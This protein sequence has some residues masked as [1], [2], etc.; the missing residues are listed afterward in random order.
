MNISIYKY[1]RC[2]DKDY[3]E[4]QLTNDNG[5]KVVLLNYG[6]TLEKILLPTCK[7]PKNVIMT[8]PGSQSYS[9]ERNFLGG[10]VG[11]VVGRIKNGKWNLGQ[12][13]IQFPLNDGENHIHGGNGFDTRVFA[14]STRYEK[15][16]VKATFLL[17]D[18]DNNNGYPGN[19]KITVTYI[20]DNNNKLSYKINAQSDQLTV[21]NPT[22]HVYFRLDGQK[23]TVKNSQLKIN[24]DFYMPLDDDSIP[25]EGIKSVTDTIFDFRKQKKIG[26]VLDSSN[27]QIQKEKGLNHP[28]ILSGKEPKI[29]L[30]SADAKISMTMETNAPAVIVYTANHFDNTGIAQEIGQYDGVALEAQ[31]PPTSSSD[32]SQISLMPGELFHRL[33]TWQ[34]KFE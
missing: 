28:F 7:G 30:T 27:S 25:S 13:I 15:K 16:H 11:R 14:F 8:L 17:L 9:K 22:N 10:T 6:A 18:P 19:I 4:I 26:D 3:C 31:F 1:Q 2:N 20:L 32:L 23:E 34:F 5:M 21:F 29:F 33:I 12:R 24:S